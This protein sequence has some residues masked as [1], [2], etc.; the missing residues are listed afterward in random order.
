MKTMLF[1]EAR[2]KREHKNGN[3]VRVRI[4]HKVKR[5]GRKGMG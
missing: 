3:L 2:E 5:R 4:T 1:R